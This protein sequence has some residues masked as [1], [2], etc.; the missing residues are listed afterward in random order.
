MGYLWVLL[1]AAVCGACNEARVA[2]KPPMKGR[3]RGMDCACAG[4][5]PGQAPGAAAPAAGGGDAAAAAGAAAGA[6]EPKEDLLA[7]VEFDGGLR[8]P[9][10]IY[11]RLYDYQKTGAAAALAS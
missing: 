2:K 11:N 4:I 7:D 1:M 3:G 8:V 10:D 9:G 6:E 5:A